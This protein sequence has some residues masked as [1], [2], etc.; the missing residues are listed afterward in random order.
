MGKISLLLFAMALVASLHVYEAHRM[1]RFDEA[2]EKDFHKAEALIEE[3]LN[4]TKKS[5]QGLTS[6]MK[7]L[8]KSE[9]MLNQLGKDYKKDMDV[10]PYGKKLRTFSRAAKNATKAPPAKNKKP[11]SVIQTILKDFGLNGGRE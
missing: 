1:G 6:E 8:S 9:E 4:A 11:A 10:A 7:T 2:L 5:I 3:D